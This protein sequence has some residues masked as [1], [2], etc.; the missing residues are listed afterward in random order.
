MDAPQQSSSAAPRATTVIGLLA[1]AAL[2]IAPAAPAAGFDRLLPDE[3]RRL[4]TEADE[5]HTLS[6]TSQVESAVLVVDDLRLF[7]LLPPE[8]ADAQEDDTEDEQAPPHDVDETR[9][10][11]HVVRAGESLADIARANGLKEIDDWRRIYDAN[12]D[13]SD[14]DVVEVGTRLRIPDSTEELARRALPTPPRTAARAS[15]GGGGADVWDRLAA[16]ESGGNWA[17]NT[18]NGYFGG[19]QFSARS[20]AAVGG[21]GLPHEHSRATQIAMAERLRAAQGWG[22]WPSCS[23]RLGLR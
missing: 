10:S 11:Y 12:P 22:A 20:W 16:C 2:F 13:V 7:D 1:T 6:A 9:G 5:D 14:P 18:G 15:R 4:L 8:P 21:T 3:D 23:R 19:L 17:A